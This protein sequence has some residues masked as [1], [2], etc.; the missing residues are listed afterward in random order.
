MQKF[1]KLLLFI[2]DVESRL[3]KR[4]VHEAASENPNAILT[5]AAHAEIQKILDYGY[6]ILKKEFPNIDIEC[7]K[8]RHLRVV[9]GN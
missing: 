9:G 1:S 8:K 2:M 4:L 3:A 5:N 6:D 7:E